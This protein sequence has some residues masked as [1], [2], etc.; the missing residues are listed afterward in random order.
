M[1][2][3][4]QPKNP[5]TLFLIF[6]LLLLATNP[7]AEEKLALLKSAL[8]A[9]QNTVRTLRQGWENFHLQMTGLFST[10]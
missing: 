1:P 5:Y 6:V 4:L 8:E 7:V 3:G 10:P 9:T 2:A